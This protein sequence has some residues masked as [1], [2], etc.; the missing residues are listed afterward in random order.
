MRIPGSIN[1]K[2]NT[3]IKIIQKWNG[4]RPPIPREFI[5]DFRTYLEQKITDQENNNYNYKYNNN[6]QNH[7]NN[8]NNSNNRIEWIEK[9]LLQ[10]PIEDGR[11]MALWRI[12]CPYL[13]NVR[14]L[15]YDE[16]FQILREWLDKCNSVRKL[17]FNPNQEIRERLK[18]AGNFYPI[19]I[20]RL[21]TA[22]DSKYR[23]LYILLLQKKKN[24]S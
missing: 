1:Y 14:K 2:Y 7:Y 4:Y 15:S 19:G 3:K 22:D 5:E 6:S 21:K 23:K 9:L 13:I 12:L 20:Q 16:S 11:K 24:V 8:S 17:D 18:R 10:T